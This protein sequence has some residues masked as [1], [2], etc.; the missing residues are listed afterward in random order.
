MDF[1][2]LSFRVVTAEAEGSASRVAANSSQRSL[3]A[4]RRRLLL[5]PKQ[6]RRSNPARHEWALLQT[7]GDAELYIGKIRRAS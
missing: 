4:L 1:I 6:T 3:S 2:S 5:T 7:L